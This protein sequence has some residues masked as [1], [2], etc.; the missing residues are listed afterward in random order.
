M[1]YR[2]L[3]MKKGADMNT[4]NRK[5]RSRG[6]GGRLDHNIPHCATWHSLFVMVDNDKEAA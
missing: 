5:G 6:A 1:P 3:V 2:V 4:R